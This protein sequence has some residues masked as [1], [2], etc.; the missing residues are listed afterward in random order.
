M[1]ADA[2]GNGFGPRLTIE[3]NRH[4]ARLREACSVELEPARITSAR[5]PAVGNDGVGIGASLHEIIPVDWDRRQGCEQA[6]F[7]VRLADRRDATVARATAERGSGKAWRIAAVARRFRKKAP[8]IVSGPI[9][10]I[11]GVPEL[12]ITT[13]CRP[14]PVTSRSGV[15]DIKA[16]N[17]PIAMGMKPNRRTR[18]LQRHSHNSPATIR[19]NAQGGI[20]GIIA[21][22]PGLEATE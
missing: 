18:V 8:D 6:P 10:Q 22:A 5:Q 21:I 17:A 16:A 2:V 11:I 14:S 3:I 20:D 15:G 4:S 1:L 9:G 19:P 13:R 7:P 12:S